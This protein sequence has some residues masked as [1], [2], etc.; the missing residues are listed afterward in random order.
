MVE[1]LRAFD[2]SYIPRASHH[3]NVSLRSCFESIAKIVL[4]RMKANE[5]IRRICTH[6]ALTV[7]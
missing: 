2:Y 6:L 3:D 4:T 5:G 1:L 7:A